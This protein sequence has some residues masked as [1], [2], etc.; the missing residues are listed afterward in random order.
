MIAFFSFYVFV[1]LLACL[2]VYC[3]CCC[4]IVPHWTKSDSCSLFLASSST[5]SADDCASLF[6]HFHRHVIVSSKRIP[7]SICLVIKTGYCTFSVKTQKPHDLESP[8]RIETGSYDRTVKR[9]WRHFETSQPFAVD[10]PWGSK[11]QLKLTYAPWSM[12]G[13]R[14]TSK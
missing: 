1:C 12:N 10:R 2:L 6:H 3:C 11:W 7:L 8:P 13:T 14:P 5:Y 4:V 9:R